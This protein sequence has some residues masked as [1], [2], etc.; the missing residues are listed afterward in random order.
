MKHR[1]TAADR[2]DL[3]EKVVFACVPSLVCAK[4]NSEAVKSLSGS[5]SQLNCV[6]STPAVLVDW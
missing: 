3:T 1:V 5:V 2:S 4:H 6:K